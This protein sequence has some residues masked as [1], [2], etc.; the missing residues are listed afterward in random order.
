F[1]SSRD[2]ADAIVTAVNDMP[3]L[4]Y[5]H[6]IPKLFDYRYEVESYEKPIDEEINLVEEPEGGVWLLSGDPEL[7][8]TSGEV[9]EGLWGSTFHLDHYIFDSKPER[10]FY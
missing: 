10:R 7:T 5:D 4:L 8:R 2:G 6:I 3:D 1:R 9:D